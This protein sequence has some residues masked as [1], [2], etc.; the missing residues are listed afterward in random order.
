MKLFLNPLWIIYL[1]I[2][3]SSAS[4][5]DHEEEEDDS[6]ESENDILLD[7]EVF[8]WNRRDLEPLPFDPEAYMGSVSRESSFQC[9]EFTLGN[10]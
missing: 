1:V 7:G 8:Q 3:I 6:T 10:V 2:H 9:N 4:S 5:S